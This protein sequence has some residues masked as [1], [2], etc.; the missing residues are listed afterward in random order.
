MTPFKCYKLYLALKRHFSDEKYDF[1]KYNGKIRANEASF[2]ARK[3]RGLFYSLAKHN[4]PIKLVLANLAY[5]PHAYVTD[6][7]S[8]EGLQVERRFT[9]YHETF[10]YSFKEELKRYPIFDKAIKV[11]DGQYPALI[12]DFIAR[13]ISI[14]TI[15]TVD[16]IINGCEYWSSQLSDPLW[17]DIN[18]QLL[19]YR[20]FFDISIRKYKTII[21]GLYDE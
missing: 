20:P 11:E 2:E 14:D 5:N 17:V 10:E 7:L 3:D 1:F 19:K 16:K 18:M 6:I 15:S 9:K 8:E 21:L 13:E 12:Q 4:N